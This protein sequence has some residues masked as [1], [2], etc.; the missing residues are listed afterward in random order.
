MQRLA[1]YRLKNESYWLSNWLTYRINR[2]W[3]ILKS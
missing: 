2:L 3:K 1:Y